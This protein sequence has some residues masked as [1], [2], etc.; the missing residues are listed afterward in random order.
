GHNPE[1][2]SQ[3]AR[4]RS[5]TPSSRVLPSRNL[6]PAI[7]WRPCR[8]AQPPAGVP[9]D[10]SG[11]DTIPSSVTNW[12]TMTL[13][14]TSTLSML[15]RTYRRHRRDSSGCAQDR[16][17]KGAGQLD[18]LNH[19]RIGERGV[20]LDAPMAEDEPLEGVQAVAPAGVE[21]VGSEGG[22][23]VGGNLWS[24]PVLSPRLEDTHHE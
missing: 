10:P 23:P 18:R 14:M 19:R 20:A 1:N 9:S 17:G 4:P 16:E 11:S 3:V 21:R 5:R 24:P 8:S 7:S 13:T 2:S 22:L 6:S 12:M 15:A